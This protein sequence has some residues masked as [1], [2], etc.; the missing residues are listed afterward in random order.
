MRF[1]TSSTRRTARLSYSEVAAHMVAS[2]EMIMSTV[3]TESRYLIRFDDICSTMNW[4]VWD[5]IESQL[6]RYAV[7]P[8]LAVV[9]DNRDPNLIVDPPRSDFWER[10]RRWQ[11]RGYTI[12]LHG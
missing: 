7:R 4:L 10:V 12:A 1:T 6:I 3:M 11:S 5:A 8:I 9:P 2:V